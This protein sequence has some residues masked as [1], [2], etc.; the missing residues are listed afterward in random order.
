MWIF[1]FLRN[2]R[3]RPRRPPFRGAAR[4]SVEQNGGFSLFDRFSVVWPR[5]GDDPDKRNFALWW[6]RRVRTA[7]IPV[8]WRLEVHGVCRGTF[9]L[10]FVRGVSSTRVET[11]QWTNVC[12]A[13][14]F[15]TPRSRVYCGE[16]RTIFL[17][18]QIPG[19]RYLDGLLP[20]LH[21]RYGYQGIY[22]GDRVDEK[23]VAKKRKSLIDPHF[24]LTKSIDFFF[25]FK[26]ITTK[27]KTI[28]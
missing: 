27:G 11:K 28:L 2:N 20:F 14:E 6:K 22:L 15:V 4:E 23:F 18:F 7:A 26:C 19:F 24:A 8:G 3:C 16:T 21:S 12:G 5:P 25:F 10:R 1:I 17:S 9:G 13:I